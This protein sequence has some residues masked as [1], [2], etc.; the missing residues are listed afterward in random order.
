MKRFLI[1]LLLASPVVALS[2]SNFQKGY[3]VTNSKD[4]LKGYI[5]LKER[6]T[7]PTSVIF[8]KSKGGE[9]QVFT[10]KDCAGYGVYDAESFRRYVVN[11]SLNEIDIA[12][13]SIGKNDSSKR[14]TVLLKVLQTGENLDLFVYTDQL[15]QRFYIMDKDQVEPV[16]LARNRYFREPGVSAFVDDKLYA[17]QLLLVMNKLGI[18]TAADQQ[19][20]LQTR[21]D[22]SSFEKVAALINKQ[23]LAKSKHSSS[24]F[25]A[26]AGVMMTD[27]KYSGNYDLANPLAESKSSVM[28][29]L[30]AGLDL[31]VINPAV[32]R[33]IFRT[34]LSFLMSKNEIRYSGIKHH[35]DQITFVLTPQF[36]YNI[37]N[38]D[39]FKFFAGG[40]LG[41][42]Y[43]ITSNNLTTFESVTGPPRESGIQIELQKFNYSVML[44]AGV[45][46]NKKIEISAGYSPYSAVTDYQFISI[47][48]RQMR[49][50][51]NYLLGKH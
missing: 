49:V 45:V 25:F 6:R 10:V 32:R 1:T 17:R 27:V 12:K 3:V 19:R 50:G 8:S 48:K 28:P 29:M 41:L 26:G 47:G 46:L 31:F 42:N 33:L 21:Y 24:R 20:V 40:G 11:I 18:G 39:R 51:L 23:E 34:E 13:L 38:A 36:L 2:Q 15:K 44:M 35:F 43:S 14:D 5:N 4:T 16:E 30:T 9:S 37:Y 22:Q 7:N